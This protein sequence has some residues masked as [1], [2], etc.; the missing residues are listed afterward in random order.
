MRARI[1]SLLSVLLTGAAHAQSPSSAPPGCSGCAV[2]AQ[3]IDG[4]CQF[5]CTQDS[6]CRHENVCVETEGRGHCEPR[7]PLR[8]SGVPATLR[9]GDLNHPERFKVI[10]PIPEGFHLVQAP[11]WELVGRGIVIF[12][13]A[14]LPV[15][16]DALATRSPLLAVPVA[17]PITG[18]REANGL[19][20]VVLTIDVVGQLAGLCMVI[21]GFASQAKWLERTAASNVSL[22]AASPSVP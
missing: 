7:L 6:D 17:G 19:T 12:I 22:P 13:L 15:A 9:R 21:A 16:I 18:F 20:V 14:W 11:N 5:P 4:V 3:C 10:S 1:F 2:G 8:R